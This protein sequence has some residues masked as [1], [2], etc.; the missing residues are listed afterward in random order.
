LNGTRRPLLTPQRLGLG[1]ILAIGAAVRLLLLLLWPDRVNADEA[2]VGLMGL[3]ILRGEFPIFFSGQGYMGG[4]E[5]YLT[6][7]VYVLAGVSS[8]TLKL[9]VFGV[10]CL[11]LVP[12]FFIGQRVA[13]WPGGLVSTLLAAIAPPFLPLFGNYPIG[14]YP[15]VVVMGSLILLLTLA[16]VTGEP[17]RA[18]RER[19]LL[20]LA[21]VAGL[22]WWTNAMTLSYLVAAGVFLLAPQLWSRRALWLAP[23]GFLLGSLPFWIFNLTHAFWSFALFEGHTRGAY[24][25]RLGKTLSRLFEIAGVWDP[26]MA[27]VAWL[28]PAAGLVYLVLLAVL[29]LELGRRP[30]AATPE[31]RAWRRGVQ[32]LLLFSLVHVAAFALNRFALLGG[33]QRYLFPLYSA[34][35]VLTGVAVLRS[36]R[37]SRLLAA[38]ALAVLLLNNGVALGR[39][40]DFLDG[41]RR[42]D[43]WKVEPLAARLQAEGVTHAYAGFWELGPSVTFAARERVIVADPFEYRYPPYREAVDAAARV[44]YVFTGR[45][46]IRTSEFESALRGIGA[47]FRRTDVDGF[48]FY[49]GFEPPPEAS[50]RVSPRTGGEPRHP[51]PAPIP[52]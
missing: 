17:D 43:W 15:E 30:P 37:W 26:L 40:I 18:T 46:G 35:P 1:V 42:N 47:Q 52:P 27:P 16:L 10:S 49:S 20:V 28:S 9:G 3:Q 39:T 24:Q 33:T 25:A 21:I 31:A 51:P 14:G 38:G 34:L 7:V 29:V 12:T 6:A 5:A 32:L 11:L 19:R 44:A 8:L 2:T 36:W 23:L 22:G 4:P 41:A 13:G 45:R 48:G 50:S